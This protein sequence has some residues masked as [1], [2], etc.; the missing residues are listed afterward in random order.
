MRQIIVDYGLV[1]IIRES[2]DMNQA[3][4]IKRELLARYPNETRALILLI[5]PLVRTD[6]SSTQVR[7]LINKGN[8]I[9][10]LVPETVHRYIKEKSLFSKDNKL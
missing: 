9:R 10:Y 1:V 8:S 7:D 5:N 2:V 3:L 6:I 4:E